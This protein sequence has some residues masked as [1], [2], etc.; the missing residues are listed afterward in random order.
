MGIFRDKNGKRVKA[1]DTV[2]IETT[3]SGYYGQGQKCIVL[4]DEENGQYRYR[5]KAG[6]FETD[7]NFDGVADF[8]K[9]VSPDPA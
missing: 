4:W 1:G 6:N 9:V 7:A 5:Y 3:Y 2:L 8:I